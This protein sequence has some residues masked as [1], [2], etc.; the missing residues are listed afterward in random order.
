MNFQVMPIMTQLVN[1][2]ENSNK[3]VFSKKGNRTVRK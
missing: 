1:E 3:S 2:A